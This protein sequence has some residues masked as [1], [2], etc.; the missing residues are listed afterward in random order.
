MS[1]S[2]D[3]ECIPQRFPKGKQKIM[4]DLHSHILPGV[5]DGP[6]DIEETRNMARRYI[7]HG[8]T[9][10]AATSHIRPGMFVTDESMLQTGAESLRKDFLENGIKLR[11]HD[12]AEYYYDGRFLSMID[13]PGE[14]LTFAGMGKYILMEFNMLQKPMGL[15]EIVFRLKLNGVTPIMAHPER[16]PFIAGDFQW[17]ERMLEAGMLLQGT[18]GCFSGYWGSGSRKT[19]KRLLDA[20]LVH[21]ISSDIH[22]AS[23]AGRYLKDAVSRLK[24]YIGDTRSE[25]LLSENPRKIL[26]GENVDD[27]V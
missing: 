3:G 8:F 14:L 18:L 11:I 20:G 15:R 9:D 19:L 27:A 22:R 1:P 21:I 13:R 4:I 6:E 17:V 25:L 26:A 12:G 23:Q 24:A 16:Y 5:D 2:T 10:V 7:E